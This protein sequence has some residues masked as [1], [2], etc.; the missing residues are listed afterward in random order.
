MAKQTLASYVYY[1]VSSANQVLSEGKRNEKLLSVKVDESSFSEPLI[2]SMDQENQEDSSYEGESQEW[3]NLIK[4]GSRLVCKAEDSRNFD[5]W[6]LERKKGLTGRLNRLLNPDF[7]KH[8][9][10]YLPA[11]EV[12]GYKI[13]RHIR[14][15][16]YRRKK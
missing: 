4:S 6:V 13:L 1:K 8:P 11:K 10:K 16:T 12:S 14:A 2:L 9:A 7:E 5:L 15:G 3:Y